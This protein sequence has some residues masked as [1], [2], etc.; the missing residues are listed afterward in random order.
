MNQD[1]R[2]ELDDLL[3]R[4]IASY[5]AAEP[6]AGLEER[7]MQRVT[8][9]QRRGWRWLVIA[10]PALAAL[11]IAVAVW[12]RP[13]EGVK[14]SPA[15]ARVETPAP[16][17]QPQPQP[18]QKPLRVAKVAPQLPKRDQFPSPSVLSPE[19]RALVELAT[20][21]PPVAEKLNE[22]Q[23]KTASEVVIAPIE[24]APLD[25]GGQ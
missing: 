20:K 8:I 23:E 3:D 21:H 7:V 17:Q 4:G 19:E 14:P 6:L 10:I 12:R 5:S 18:Q 22:W 2:D 11:L 1:H 15:V 25:I 9:A 16:P 13:H 24:I